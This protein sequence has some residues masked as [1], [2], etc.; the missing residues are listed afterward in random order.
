AYTLSGCGGGMSFDGHYLLF[1]KQ[2]HSGYQI[3]N[4]NYPGGIAS[5]LVATGS[6][7][8]MGS[9]IKDIEC[10]NFH[11][12]YG[13]GGATNDTAWIC[14]SLA[15]STTEQNLFNWVTGENVITG[16]GDG[17]DFWVGSSVQTSTMVLNPASLTF[18]ANLGATSPAAKTVQI[19]NSG[20]GTLNTVTTTTSYSSGSGWLTV[21]AG[22]SGNAQTLTNTVALGSLAIGSYSATVNVTCTNAQP[23]TGSYA[24]AFQVTDPSLTLANVT[25]SP[26]IC[27]TS[28]WSTILYSAAATA[29]NGSSLTPTFKWTVSGQSIDSTS[30]IFSAGSAAGGPYT[31][32]AT[33]AY[34][35]VTKSATASVLVYRPVTIT[36][37]VQAATYK[38][39]D[40]LTISWTRLANTTTTGLDIQFTAD[41]GLTWS[42]L[43]ASVLIHDGNAAY[44]NGN[45]GT[46]KWKI[47][48]SFVNSI[49]TTINCASSQCKVELEAPYD[50]AVKA[51]KDVSGVFSIGGTPGIVTWGSPAYVKDSTDVIKTGTLKY[52]YVW[53]GTD[54]TLNGVPFKGTGSSTNVGTSPYNLTIAPVSGSVAPGVD[55][56]A[57]RVPDGVTG[58]YGNMLQAG[59]FVD[60]ADKYTI[61]LNNLTSGHTYQIQIW[62]CDAYYDGGNTTITCGDSVVLDKSKVNGL[63][64]GQYVIGTF[65]AGA[66]A[67]KLTF[68]GTQNGSGDKGPVI[69]A[70]QVRE[71]GTSGVIAPKGNIAAAA[72]NLQ[73]AQNAR[74]Y[75]VRGRMIGISQNGKLPQNARSG[76]YILKSADAGVKIIRP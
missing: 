4:L 18:A 37:P 45:V 23:Q 73:N 67:P 40:T 58:S 76:I 33:A 3:Y 56:M 60:Y 7:P 2:D 49:G 14:R 9:F 68:S 70:L 15:S 71:G 48:Q 43:I 34:N 31:V 39:G 21:V 44:Y 72:A 41:N 28:T 52:A 5:T 11:N 69:N 42:S 63:G 25:V 54:K 30:G 55:Q 13:S 59:L 64:A 32:T 36:A 17:G 38:I 61:T 26:A 22:G 62:S 24:V 10:G 35:G 20:N 16:L 6:T 65:T 29:G 75:D 8:I 12:W 47:P 74:I 19:A 57:F 50:P 53:I 46:F 51:T 1:G 66:T 27:T